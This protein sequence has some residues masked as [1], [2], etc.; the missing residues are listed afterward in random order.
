MMLAHLG[1]PEEE[2]RI[3]GAVRRAVVEKKCTGDVGGGLGTAAA[4][5]WVREEIRRSLAADA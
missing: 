5:A 3:E 4:G 2:R 1:W